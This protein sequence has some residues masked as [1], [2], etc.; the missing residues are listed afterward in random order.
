MTNWNPEPEEAQQPLEQLKIPALKV[1]ARLV[2]EDSDCQ[3]WGVVKDCHL[4]V[5]HIPED[6][7]VV[8]TWNKYGDGVFWVSLTTPVEALADKATQLFVEL[9]ER[10][11]RELATEAIV[12]KVS[13]ARA[14]RAKAEPE[15]EPEPDPL[16]AS[17]RSRLGR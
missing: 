13:K 5:N 17:L 1:K 8:G 14:K 12:P 16:Y 4:N 3:E 7:E 9:A 6:A 2:L 10:R 11:R 15:P